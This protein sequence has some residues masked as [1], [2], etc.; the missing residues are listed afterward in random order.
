LSAERLTAVIETYEA[1]AAD[2]ATAPIDQL[3]AT[4]GG[5]A[6]NLSHDIDG[7]LRQADEPLAIE[8][9]QSVLN[10][11]REFANVAPSREVIAAESA[12]TAETIAEAGSVL[13]ILS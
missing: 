1:V 3:R 8:L 11:E 2:A 5:D 7:P 13:G 6:H 4:F 12:A 10:I 9:C